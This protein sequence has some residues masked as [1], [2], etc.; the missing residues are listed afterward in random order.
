LAKTASSLET[1]PQQLGKQ[2]RECAV[3]AWQPNSASLACP[4]EQVPHDS[5]ERA[6]QHYSP[7]KLWSRILYL[8]ER[9][10]SNT[11]LLASLPIFHHVARTNLFTLFEV[12]GILPDPVAIKSV[13]QLFT[14]MFHVHV[15]I[16][17]SDD[18]VME[19]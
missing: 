16:W 12:P 14:L 6:A 2:M 17:Y 9:T 1:K 18:Q 4:S 10:N 5:L 8:T 7:T 13:E 3:Y 15:A 11:V 19:M